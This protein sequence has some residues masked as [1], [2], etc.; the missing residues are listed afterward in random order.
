MSSK[1]HTLVV[2]RG[3]GRVDVAIA[4]VLAGG[5]G[6]AGALEVAIGPTV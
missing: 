6:V 5:A 4:F 2:G 1:P 3:N